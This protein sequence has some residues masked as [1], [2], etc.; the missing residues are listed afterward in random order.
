ME[1]LFGLLFS[2]PER[3]LRA[4]QDRDIHLFRWDIPLRGELWLSWILLPHSELLE[5]PNPVDPNCMAFPLENVSMLA[6][7]CETVSCL[8]PGV[9]CECVCTDGD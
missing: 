5:G 6:C 4:Y 2:G 8:H 3:L 7:V 1:A 9:G